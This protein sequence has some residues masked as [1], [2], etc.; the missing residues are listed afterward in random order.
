MTGIAARYSAGDQ[1]V[2]MIFGS[3]DQ[4]YVSGAG[5]V[6]TAKL[7]IVPVTVSGSVWVPLLGNAVTAP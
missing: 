7:A 6:T 1:L 3:E 5:N 4:Y 2:L